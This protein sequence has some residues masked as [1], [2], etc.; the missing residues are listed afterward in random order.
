[1]TEEEQKTGDEQARKCLKK[2]LAFYKTSVEKGNYDFLKDNKTS[3]GALAA[4]AAKSG[5]HPREV[6][7]REVQEILLDDG[8]YL[9]PF[10]DLKPSDE[11]FRELQ[12]AGIEG[13]VHGIGRSV[14]WSNETW[15]TLPE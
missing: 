13:R 11:G 15:V 9:L 2:E 12:T 7:V 6:P 3:A 10:L 4:V 14:D 8:C 1:M 5:R